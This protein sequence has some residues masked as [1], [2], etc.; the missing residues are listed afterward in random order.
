ML[1]LS[2]LARIAEVFARRLQMQERLT[3]QIA[4]ALM[5]QTG[6]RGV[7]VVLDCA[8]MCMCMRGVQKPGTRTTTDCM[9][10]EFE[11]DGALR[12]EFTSHVHAPR[13]L[14]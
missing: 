7:A 2:K 14:L 11:T 5:E 1:G 13:S 4:H 3:D 6:A 10:G 8:H 12:R 9:L